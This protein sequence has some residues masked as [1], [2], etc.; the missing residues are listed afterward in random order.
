M[1]TQVSKRRIGSPSIEEARDTSPSTGLHLLPALNLAVGSALGGVPFLTAT[2]WSCL[3]KE[4]AGRLDARRRLARTCLRESSFSKEQEA[5]KC[6][7]A[8][9]KSSEKGEKQGLSP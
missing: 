7:T 1:E 2:R 4:P 5:E 8:H 9:Q 3:L 6:A